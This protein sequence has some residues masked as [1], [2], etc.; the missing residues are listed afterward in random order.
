MDGVQI[1][2][3]RAGDRA[4]VR[5]VLVRSFGRAVV[6]D[7][8]EALQQARAE[9]TGLT[10]VA[11]LD[12]EL[13]GYVQLSRS[14][15]DARERL[16]EVLVL[17]PLGVVPEHQRHGIGGRLVN[18]ALR[19]GAELATPLIFLEGSPDY[20]SRFGFE[21]ASRRGFTAPSVRIPDA[22][23]QVLIL[24]SY[25]SWIT[26]ALVYPEAFWAFDCVGVRDPGV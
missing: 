6:A 19:A 5:D 15:L 9:D 17:G 8:A 3:R 18:R 26:G 14:W 20:Y 4:G 13:V 16:V 24:P 1:R 11:E 12:G 7:L 10:F 2:G 25:R 22:A 21:T 23:F